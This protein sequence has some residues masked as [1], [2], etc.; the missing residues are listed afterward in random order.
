MSWRR[1]TAEDVGEMTQMIE[2]AYH[3]GD[4]F[5]VDYNLIDPTTKQKYTRTSYD[6]IMKAVVS[7]TVVMEGEEEERSG[8]GAGSSFGTPSS[9]FMVGEIMDSV[10]GMSSLG[11]CVQIHSCNVPNQAELSYLTVSKNAQGCGV[12]KEAM[13][14]A[15]TIAI[16]TGYYSIGIDVV[17]TKPWL[18]RFYEKLG[19]TMTGESSKWPVPQYLKND[20]QGMFFHRQTKSMI[21]G[22]SCIHA[23]MMIPSPS[24]R[25]FYN[26]LDEE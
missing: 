10:T 14:I 9:T 8:A 24:T 21:E 18:S 2:I 22:S 7:S 25:N 11:A 15:E 4:E 17:S 23:D 5:F 19:Y 1:A 12:A 6:Q 26:P 3:L 13:N 20:F 16:N